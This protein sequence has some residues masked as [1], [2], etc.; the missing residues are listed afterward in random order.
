MQDFLE[1][2]TIQTE[3]RANIKH[4]SGS[5][6]WYTPRNL[7]ESARNVMG[8]IDLD[9]AS[10]AIANET[11]FADDYFTIF[12]DGLTKEWS[13]KVFCNP[14]GG[15]LNGKSLPKL[16]WQK[17]MNS[18]NVT[19]AIF[20]AF[21]IELLQTSQLSEQRSAGDFIICVPKRRLAFTDS[22]GKVAKSNS[23]ASA[24]VYTGVNT[25]KFI[26]EFKQYGSVLAGIS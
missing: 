16:F 18:P 13:G 22:N 23:H 5:Q 14:P 15:K 20:L 9:P 1:A 26:E 3:P 11:V 6:E 19:E 12:E 10:S 7:I 21:S 25:D 24:I 17:L 8:N 4:S 2:T